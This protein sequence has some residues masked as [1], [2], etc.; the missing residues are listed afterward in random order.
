MTLVEQNQ[1]QLQSCSSLLQQQNLQKEVFIYGLKTDV[2]HILSQAEIGVLASTDEGF[3]VTLLEY[4]LANLAV[5]STNVGYCSEIIEDEISGLL[6][7]PLNESQIK[8]QLLKVVEDNW[9]RS[10]VA[11]NLKKSVLKKYSKI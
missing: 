10:I 4:A 8:K 2:E 3:P 7:D 1:V 11:E 5:V 9:F 6:F